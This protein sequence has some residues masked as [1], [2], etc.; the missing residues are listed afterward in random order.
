M[1]VVKLQVGHDVLCSFAKPFILGPFL[2]CNNESL[3]RFTLVTGTDTLKG[4]VPRQLGITMEFLACMIEYNSLAL[5]TVQ[6]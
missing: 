1:L 3:P 4:I 5:A 6:S 2:S